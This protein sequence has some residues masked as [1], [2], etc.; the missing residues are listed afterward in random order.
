MSSVLYCEY[1]YIIISTEI[2]DCGQLNAEPGMGVWPQRYDD[3]KHLFQ[4]FV[5]GNT[6]NM[7][8]KLSF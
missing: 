4:H 7:R 1:I 3:I 6:Y 8:R 5:S 2:V